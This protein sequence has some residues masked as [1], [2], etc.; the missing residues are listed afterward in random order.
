MKLQCTIPNNSK[1]YEIEVRN[2][3]LKDLA[4]YSTTLSSRFAIVTHDSLS[5]SYA[6]PLHNSLKALGNESFIFT[7]PSGEIHKNREIKESLENQLFEKGLGRDSCVI[8]IGG[9]VVTDL[10][11]YLAATF[12]RG[13]PLVMVPTSLLAMVDASI[14]GKNGVN[15]PYGKNLIGTI[16]QPH[17]VVI[18]PNVLKT[19]PTAD[20]ING[21]VEMIKHGLI[22]DHD[23]FEYLEKNSEK[24]LKLNPEFLEKS[25][26][27]SCRIKKEIVEQDEKENGKRRLLNFGHTIGH[28]LERLSNYLLYHGEAVAIGILVESYM[29][30]LMGILDS[31]SFERIK[32]IIMDYKV[33]LRLQEKF[34]PDAILEAMRTDKKALK[35]LPR[36]VMIE[37]IGSCLDYNFSYCTQV[38]EQIVKT[39][40]QWMND[41]LCRH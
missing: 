19:L 27:D 7:F 33:P 17:K 1:S 18:D 12:C 11:G 34:T 39:A 38:D 29:S 3:L 30:T 37:K 21:V 23:Y 32:K 36:F 4:S 13:V 28:A 2:G 31:V 5:A 24:L 26:Y 25:I 9:G 16:Y 14:G 15:I 10:S 8:A 20:L 40:L 35:G 6:E 22:T 41:D